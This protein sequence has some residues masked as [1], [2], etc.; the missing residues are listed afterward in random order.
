[1]ETGQNECGAA[2]ACAGTYT[3]PTGRGGFDNHINWFRIHISNQVSHKVGPI[4][5]N[6]AIPHDDMVNREG[7]R[8]LKLLAKHELGHALGHSGHSADN[9]HHSENSDL[10]GRTFEVR[11]CS[12]LNS[13]DKF[14]IN[15][16]YL[17]TN[18][19]KNAG[20]IAADSNSPLDLS[21]EVNQAGRHSVRAAGTWSA[22]CPTVSAEPSNFLQD[23]ATYSSHAKFYRFDIDTA[24]TYS[25]HLTEPVHDASGAADIPISPVRMELYLHQGGPYAAVHSDLNGVTRAD[26][27]QLSAGSYTL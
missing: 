5:N 25:F 9:S 18:S 14:A 16:G 13:D 2:V 20:C 12:D 4:G 27:V 23:N 17:F 15:R 21:A 11:E 22:T 19:A 1:M 8:Y 6:C 7:R 3:K 24:G 26:G 10:M